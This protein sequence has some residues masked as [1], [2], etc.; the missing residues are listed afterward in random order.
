[1]HSKLVGIVADRTGVPVDRV[2]AIDA[3]LDII[4]PTIAD[5]AAMLV[6][7]SLADGSP[8]E[9][10]ESARAAWVFSNGDKT[11]G[12][13]LTLFIKSLVAIGTDDPISDLAF[14]SSTTLTH[15]VFAS[16]A[17]RVECTDGIEELAFTDDGRWCPHRDT[18]ITT[19][20]AVSGRVLFWIARDIAGF[21]PPVETRRFH[22][23]AQ[24]V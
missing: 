1:M 19:A 23:L 17:I 15:G 14:R 16:M 21:D 4:H 12:W 24:S 2:A 6:L 11:A 10:A 13:Y 20:K 22:S 18:K 3:L 7:A 8:S 5:H 9:A